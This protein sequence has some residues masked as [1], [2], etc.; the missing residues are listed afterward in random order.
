MN[1]R[2]LI[3]ALFKNPTIK[4]LYES[5]HFDASDINRAILMEASDDENSKENEEVLKMLMSDLKDLKLTYDELEKKISTMR[6]SGK[7]KEA[8]E[9]VKQ[10]N[11]VRKQIESL[12]ARIL[13]LRKA[14][15]TDVKVTK[16]AD[17]TKSQ[18]DDEV[19]RTVSMKISDMLDG[20]NIDIK[21]KAQDMD[22][23]N[24]TQRIFDHEEEIDAVIDLAAPDIKKEKDAVKAAQAGEE[25]NAEKTAELA[26]VAKG[27]KNAL[28]S[29]REAITSK[30]LTK[31]KIDK[32]TQSPEAFREIF[33][34][35]SGTDASTALAQF[36]AIDTDWL[37]EQL[38]KVRELQ[39][40]E[41]K[42]Q[43]AAR[44][45][46]TLES[47]NNYLKAKLNQQPRFQIPKGFKFPDS[48]PKS[49]ED[50]KQQFIAP[51]EKATKEAP[52]PTAPQEQDYI[53][54]ADQVIAQAPDL[55]SKEDLAVKGMKEFIGWYVAGRSSG[56]LNE[57]D[58]PSGALTEIDKEY[59][60]R[61]LQYNGTGKAAVIKHIN[62]NQDRW[63][64]I[65]KGLEDLIKAKKISINK[66]EDKQDPSL[67][68]ESPPELAELQ[69]N[70]TDVLM[71]F[72]GKNPNKSSFMKR[73]LLRS[74]AEMLYGVMDV[75]EQI[76]D[77]EQMSAYTDMNQDDEREAQ[78]DKAQLQEVFPGGPA[79]SGVL[80]IP[81]NEPDAPTDEPEQE[82]VQPE[83]EQSQPEPEAQ[84][85]K[86]ELP[87]KT[88]R[89]I[90]QDLQSMVDLLR[91]LKLLIKDYSMYATR[92][93]ADPRF[94][95]S[96]LKANMDELL[97]QVQDDIY[98]LH[99][100]L[101]PTDLA[102]EE[103][104]ENLEEA[105]NG[106]MLEEDDPERQAKIQLVRQTY[107]NA[108]KEYIY[109]LMPSMEKPNWGKSQASAKKILDILKEEKFISLFPTG[110]KTAGGKVMTVGKAYESMTAVIQEF[111]ET[112]RDIVL[113]SKEKY[114]AK[115][116]L[117]QAKNKLKKISITIAD[118]FRVP[119]K[120]SPEEIKKAKEEEA[121]N[122][123][124]QALTPEPQ[125]RLEQK[126]GDNTT[127][128][129]T[130][131]EPV[132][133]TAVIDDEEDGVTEPEEPVNAVEINK[134]N[135]E[136]YFNLRDPKEKYILQPLLSFL[137]KMISD[138]INESF[139]GKIRGGFR[140]ATASRKKIYK[141][142]E[143]DLEGIGIPEENISDFLSFLPDHMDSMLKA[144]P[145]KEIV[146]YI[147]G[148]FTN[149]LVQ[150]IFNP[151][152]IPSVFLELAG[153]A[154]F[155]GGK[156]PREKTEGQT[157]E[158][159]T[160][161][162]YE[163]INGLDVDSTYP[164]LYEL[165][166]ALKGFFGTKYENYFKDYVE[167]SVAMYPPDEESNQE[168]TAQ[169]YS[170][171]FKK[172]G[173][174]SKIRSKYGKEVYVYLGEVLVQ[175]GEAHG[176]LEDA[177]GAVFML[178][179]EEKEEFMK[180]Y[181]KVYNLFAKHF[182]KV[183]SGLENL[184]KFTTAILTAKQYT[185]GTSSI[186]IEFRYKLEDPNHDPILDLSSKQVFDIFEKM[187]NE[188][189]GYFE[190][191]KENLEEAL[192][193]IIKKMLK[194]HCNY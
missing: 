69:E 136:E 12:E 67:E 87:P 14:V 177:Y 140:K 86:V 128:A 18:E 181:K 70:W 30:G 104:D 31:E 37:N 36:K 165:H 187:K 33:N 103:G 111:I 35:R 182:G 77:P 143:G 78:A 129:P 21:R 89:I 17:A 94:D 178:P 91:Q 173:S 158:D 60:Q 25:P 169:Y 29:A 45:A 188:Q 162:D 71:T 26:P 106:I 49:E 90:K 108:K 41:Q 57:A 132:T 76:S 28:K 97:V 170:D 38:G 8:K 179:P 72:F 92:K 123:E 27:W 54:I 137:E 186:D 180:K 127:A 147:G 16:A 4:A 84:S 175:L 50:F 43:E 189:P 75:L 172:I 151:G 115:T 161:E 47:W 65:F 160:D 42:A 39:D 58:G 99:S 6:V 100:N 152:K 193:P 3:K 13:E 34:L 20:L 79:R 63:N 110:M 114:I 148:F 59:A 32:A 61:V 183:N 139:I 64:N 142:I 135:L 121:A 141:Q 154:N 24:I 131:E 125:K 118:L 73:L 109:V 1:K 53:Y 166:K 80:K 138:S 9:F 44:I 107:D 155:E 82:E 133:A 55:L 83:P 2:E 93:S 19:A 88:R 130:G 134:Q 145:A 46:A 52:T 11:Q 126:D 40:Q 48:T 159:I 149:E 171:L 74:Q 144:F 66:P 105:L 68:D 119:S 184:E 102:P 167:S 163:K 120:F 95:G 168:T 81:K 124:N 85:D 192:K 51:L 56:S 153:Y 98:D 194:E 116:S 190:G 157:F 176:S 62:S 113:I 146:D 156:M 23:G 22:A 191:G 7:K 174:L 150:L 15:A 5:G 122:P 112:V 185:I 164:E 10:N 101:K 96:K 117:T